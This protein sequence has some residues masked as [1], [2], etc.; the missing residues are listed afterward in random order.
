M[1]QINKKM[2]ISLL[3]ILISI[4]FLGLFIINKNSKYFINITIPN[5]SRLVLDIIDEHE[6]SEKPL[7]EFTK[8]GEYKIDKMN[9]SYAL[10][11][12]NNDYK[13]QYG[14]VNITNKY[15]ELELSLN[16]YSLKKLRDIYQTEK[17]NINETITAKYPEQMKQYSLMYGKLYLN[18]EWFGGKLV[19]E[20]FDYNDKFM[21]VMHKENGEWKV[22]V[23]P[24]ISLSKDVYPDVPGDVL[25]ELNIITRDESMDKETI[26]Q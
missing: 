6:N 12:N 19:K 23:T 9:Y 25:E 17:N 26:A 5:D 7:Y 16:E 13:T 21:V 22:V 10:I 11:P 2:V 1:V 4:V 14:E 18:G 20:G 24:D 15:T 8:S 3:I